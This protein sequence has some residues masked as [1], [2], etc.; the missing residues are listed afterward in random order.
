VKAIL[1]DYAKDKPIEIWFQDEARVG[2]QGTLTRIWAKRGTR[3]RA[4]RDRRYLWAYIFGAVCPARAAT[5][6]LVLPRADCHALSLHLVEIA[7]EVDPASHAIL[8]LD[9]A[10]YHTAA[11]LKV[12][13]NITLM[14]LPPYAPEL[15]PVE[16]IWQYLRQNKLANTVYD[17]YEAIVDTCCEAWNF[18]AD[19]VKTVTSVTTRSWASVNA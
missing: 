15:N 5:A 2:Q 13:D 14:P 16:N 4:P 19:D 17:D 11:D 3:P 10:G 1:P 9:G 18:F 12:P 7:K 8:V 6:A